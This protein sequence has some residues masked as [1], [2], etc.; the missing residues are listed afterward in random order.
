[1]RE[2]KFRLWDIGTEKMLYPREDYLYIDENGN[3]AQNYAIFMQYTGLND[4]DGTEIYEGDLFR[5][6]ALDETEGLYVIK[7]VPLWGGQFMAHKLPAKT[8]VLDND[9]ERY[10]ESNIVGNIYENPELLNKPT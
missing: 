2:I 5:Y 8:D 10:W 6:K 7:F 1:M 9:F 3:I 4:R